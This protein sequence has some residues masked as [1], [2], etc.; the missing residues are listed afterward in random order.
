[1]IA[2]KNWGSVAVLFC[3]AMGAISLLLGCSPPGTHAF[4]E[5]DRLLREGKYAPAIEKLKLATELLEENAKPRAW[6]H[7]GLAY[8]GAGQPEEAIQAYQQALRLNQNLTVTRFNLG[9]AYLDQNKLQDAISELNAYTVLDPKVAPAWLKLG[10]A[11]LRS[12]QFDAAEKS[13]QTAL[14]LH[15]ALPEALNGLGLIQIQ[16]KRLREALTFFNAALEKQPNYGPALRNLAVTY[17]SQNRLLAL[18]KYREYLEL[19]PRPPDFSTVEQIVRQIEAELN[20][21]PRLVQT[22]AAPALTNLVQATGPSA[23]AVAARA[24]TNPPPALVASALPQSKTSPANSNDLERPFSGTKP[25]AVPLAKADTSAPAPTKPTSPITPPTTTAPKEEPPPKIEIITLNN[26]LA[27][28]LPEDIAPASPPRATN[29][30][31]AAAPPS[32]P[33]DPPAQPLIRSLALREKPKSATRRVLE[34]LDPRSWFGRKSAAPA[35]AQREPAAGERATSEAQNRPVRYAPPPAP[36][37]NARPQPPQIPRYPYRSP[38]RPAAGDRTQA[39]PFFAQGLR[40]HRE[41]KLTAAIESYRQAIKFDPTYFDA[42]FNLGLAAYDVKDW[43]Q[44]LLAYE[45]ALVIDAVSADARYNFALAL[46]RAG[47]YLDAANELEKLLSD[48]PDDD[49]AH[50]A[51]AK[52]QAERLAQADSAREHYQRVLRL[53]P[54][55]PEAAAIRYWL[56]AHP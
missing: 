39:E 29:T 46:E 42:H 15:P 8:H 25:N 50:F 49:R 21:P 20:P 17:Q 35:S 4:L 14:Q 28:K 3:V 18:R 22:N 36:T 10:S 2:T 32:L 41:R 23:N 27:P 33:D 26:D 40:A 53:N 34:K 38:S 9:C 11:Y 37:V 52:L 51:L 56:A 47:F 1:M 31:L 16:R 6:N 5:G 24:P 48:R 7:L 30:L 55:H 13:Y 54:A 12:R 45:Y 43:G 19:K 44:S